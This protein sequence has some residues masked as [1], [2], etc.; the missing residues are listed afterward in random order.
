MTRLRIGSSFAFLLLAASSAG[1]IDVEGVLPASL[2]Q[3]RIYLAVSRELNGKPLVAKASGLADLLGGALGGALGGDE[4]G[5]TDKGSKE[6]TTSFAVEAF[7]DTGASGIM[8]SKPT[9]DGLGLAG[10]KTKDG[11]PVLFYDVGVGGSESFGVTAPVY[12]RLANYNSNTEGDT[13][14]DYKPAATTPFRINVQTSSGL[15][16]QLTGG[17]DVAGMPVMYDKVMVCDCRPIAK[18]DKMKTSLVAANDKTIPATDVEV[19][20]SYIDFSRFTRIEPAGAAPLQLKPNPMI[21]PNPFDPTDR[22]APVVM[23]HNGKKASLTML[24]DT[25]AASSMI[26]V[27]KAKELGI[28]FN[29][30]G[31]ADEHSEKRTVRTADRRHRRIEERARVLRRRRPTSRSARRAGAILESTAADLGHRRG[32][33]GHAPEVHARWRVRHE[34]PRRQRERQQ[35]PHRARSGR[36]P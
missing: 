15:M 12:V 20:L 26:S 4:K 22:T 8:L 2:D 24:L 19:A 9:A 25:G 6:E 14:E 1:A 34:L 3:P 21:G 27:G 35:Q 5:N 31:R 18:Y 32:R 29:D 30:A 13:L 33:P 23:T 7:L 17:L 11:K 28:T 36:Y 10:L 16:D